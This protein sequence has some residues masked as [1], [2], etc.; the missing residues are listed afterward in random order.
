MNDKLKNKHLFTRL[1]FA[2][3]GLSHA[4]SNEKSIRFQLLVGASVVLFLLVLQPAMI[5]WAIII[6]VIAMVV[7]AEL[8]N[9][10]IEVLCDFLETEHNEKIKIIKDVAAA[11]VLTTSIGAVLVAVIFVLDYFIL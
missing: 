11:A 3:A 6:V 8:F 1:R 9:T 5:W 10:A 2:L 4:V 7:S